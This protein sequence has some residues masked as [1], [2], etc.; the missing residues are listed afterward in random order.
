[1]EDDVAQTLCAELCV[2]YS[3]HA[4]ANA[5]VTNNV[6]Y[7]LSTSYPLRIEDHAGYTNY[8]TEKTQRTY[9]TYHY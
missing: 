8:T 3:K 4:S 5:E 7:L 2:R 9:S 1:M 6:H